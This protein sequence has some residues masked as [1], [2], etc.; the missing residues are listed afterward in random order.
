VCAMPHAGGFHQASWRRP[1][2]KGNDIWNPDLWRDVARTAERGLLDAVFFADNLALW[3]VPEHLRHHT[4]KVG[5]WDAV[6]AASLVATATER[7]GVIATVHTEFQQ[8]Y[9]L[10]R[11]MACLDHLSRGRIGWNIVTSGIPAEYANFGKEQTPEKELLYAR[12]TEFVEVVK[13]LWDSWEDDAYLIDQ[14]SGVFFDPD[15]LHTLDHKGEF[16]SARGPLNVMRPPQGYPVFAQ[17]GG[18]GPGKVLAGT[19]GELIFTPL[20]GEAAVAYS[21]DIRKIA[22]EAGRDPSAIKVLSQ[23]MPVVAPTDEEA[24]EKWLTLQR[25]LHPDIARG[26]IESMLGEDISGYPLDEPLPENG[27]YNG[28]K[29][30]RDA[31]LSFRMPDGRK[32]TVREL[33]ENY[34]GPGTVVGSPSTIADYMENEIA[35]GACDGFALLVQGLPEELE[36]FVDLV[37]PELQRRGR[38]RTAYPQGT[39]REQLGF[40]RPHNQ[41]ALKPESLVSQP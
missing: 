31:V 9:I 24:Q 37:V 29:G 25:L 35:S 22:A 6:I 1:G 19:V 33:I 21:K 4:A 10:A 20:T 34:K 41:F 16:Y 30:Y 15:K 39:L 13:G 5:V 14:E 2:A 11:Q 17:A 40:A 26:V 18:S 36:D 3:P 38:F 28:I 8:P 7:I 32:P 12:A 23:L 27:Q